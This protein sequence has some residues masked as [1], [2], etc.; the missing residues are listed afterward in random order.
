MA[1]AASADAAW[2][3]SRRSADTRWQEWPQKNSE[4]QPHIG[5][6]RQTQPAKIDSAINLLGPIV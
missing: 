5:L 4:V 3:G 2:R 1:L 6:I